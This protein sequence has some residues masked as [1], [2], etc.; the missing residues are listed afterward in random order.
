MRNKH[1]QVKKK[2]YKYKTNKI[3]RRVVQV[4]E[5][6]CSLAAK[7]GGS[8]NRMNMNAAKLRRKEIINQDEWPIFERVVVVSRFLPG[9]TTTQLFVGCVSIDIST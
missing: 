9:V 5:V 1:L 6:P 8:A 4:S 2:I 3:S 7:T